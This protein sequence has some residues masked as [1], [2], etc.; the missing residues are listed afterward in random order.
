M[1]KSSTG[2]TKKLDELLVKL[3]ELHKETQRVIKTLAS[4]DS[5]FFNFS[6]FHYFNFLNFLLKI[7]FF[8]LNSI[9]LQF[10]SLSVLK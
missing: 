6:F 3:E 2:S 8:S 1:E 10:I 4:N 5:N 9:E 7:F